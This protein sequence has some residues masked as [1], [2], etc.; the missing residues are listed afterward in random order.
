[1]SF[2]ADWLTLRAPADDR[3]RDQGLLTRL[4]NGR[5]TARF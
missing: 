5:T 4:Q 1:M 3:A 2:S